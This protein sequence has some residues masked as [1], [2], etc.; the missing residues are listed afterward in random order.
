[1]KHQQPNPTEMS[2][3]D[4]EV[5]TR[6]HDLVR[7][8]IQSGKRELLLPSGEHRIQGAWLPERFCHVTNNDHG[9]KRI[10]LDFEGAE[11]LSVDGQGASLLFFGEVMPIR[12]GRS[13]GVTL[14]H[15]TIDWHRPFFTQ[16]TVKESGDGWITFLYDPS[17]YPLRVDGGRLIAHDGLG[18]QTEALW[19]LLPFDPARREVSS[20]RENWHLGRWHRASREG[21]D[22]IR[23][24]AAFAENY[25]SGT[26]IVLMHGNRVAPGIWVEDSRDIVLRDITL[27]HAPAMG[28]VA[29]NSSD[30]TLERICVAPSGDRLFSSWVDA[31][32]FNDCGGTT[33]L[34][35]CD[36]RG[37]FDDACN[38]HSTFFRVVSHPAPRQARVQVVHPQRWGSSP[39]SAGSQVAFFRHRDMERLLVTRVLESRAINQEFCD[40]TVEDDLPAEASALICSR[41]D[42]GSTIEVRGCRFGANRGRGLLIN[43]E[44][45][46]VVEGNHIHV[47]GRAIESLP[48]ANYWW[49]GSP[50]QN[51][52]IRGNTFEDCGYG[53]CGGDTIFLGPEL[54]DGADPRQGALHQAG[55]EKKGVAQGVLRQVLIADNTVIRHRGRFLHAHGVDGLTVTGNQIIQSTRYPLAPE[56]PLVHLGEGVLNATIQDDLL[57]QKEKPST[58]TL[59]P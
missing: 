33:R 5:A 52:T 50:V 15:L 22:S 36:L 58:E 4:P 44:H 42:T 43:R 3:P 7:D 19:N 20:R 13:T 57:S 12:V 18:W 17:R 53:P 31:T 24:E 40:I 38:I 56:E 35:D 41:F 45:R 9:L 37:Q 23:I 2:L 32:H 48:D 29:Q 55:G 21:E 47:S 11:N 34:I 39:L 54:P 51:L 6:L 1:M 8:A 14:R 10:L 16:A 30:I 26:P 49:E 46:T 27:H 28:I 25:P 59:Q